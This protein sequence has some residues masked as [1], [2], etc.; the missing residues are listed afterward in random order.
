VTLTLEPA[1]TLDAGAV[2]AIL[3]AGTD[4]AEWLPRIYSRAEELSFAADM[5]AAGWVTIARK[6]LETIGFSALRGAELHALYVAPDQQ[7]YGIGSQLLQAAQ[8]HHWEPW[9]RLRLGTL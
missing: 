4:A 1:Q 2:G 7:G 9:S 3:S 5:I 8:S 6:G